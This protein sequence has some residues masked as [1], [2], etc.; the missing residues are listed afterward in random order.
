MNLFKF[1]S[2]AVLTLTLYGCATTTG[3]IGKFGEDL[4]VKTCEGAGDAHE[5]KYTIIETSYT[6]SF[7]ESTP[8]KHFS[9]IKNVK[10]DGSKLLLS[11]I[12]KSLYEEYSTPLVTKLDE[13]HHD[14]HLLLPFLGGLIYVP[15][16]IAFS[17]FLIWDKKWR[18]DVF[19]GSTNFVFGCTEKRLQSPELDFT[20]KTK[21][22]KTEWRDSPSPHTFLISGF[23]KDYE[24]DGYHH[25]S[26]G[27]DID[28]SKAILNTDLTKKTTVKITCL[29]CDL[30]GPEEQ[31]LY[32]D[33][34]KTVEITADFREIKATLVA[35]E[36]TKEKLQ[37]Q[38][39]KEAAIQRTID[40]KEDL[41][42]RKETQGVPLN[43]FKAQCTKLGFKVGTTDFGNCVLELND[44]K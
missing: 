35:E 14:A 37:A 16:S 29:D 13:I 22:G 40:K 5:D 23:D 41:Q 10:I 44:S 19:S 3:G 28:I 25:T 33:V 39:D 2:I 20:K 12:D 9:G 4:D 32:K 7:Q 42:R 27:V 18:T 24:R 43:K 36:K 38:L 26:Q 11:L 15:F 21:T 17:P 30:L 8:I 31:N 6:P 1:P 34:K